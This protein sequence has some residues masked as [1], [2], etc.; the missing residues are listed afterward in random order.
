MKCNRRDIAVEMDRARVGVVVITA[1]QSS[2]HHRFAECGNRTERVSPRPS[3]RR[4]SSQSTPII[5]GPILI[6]ANF[7]VAKSI[8]FQ[9]LGKQCLGLG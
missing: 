8:R 9:I 5:P 3:D 7:D 6:E 4:V 2:R 1:K